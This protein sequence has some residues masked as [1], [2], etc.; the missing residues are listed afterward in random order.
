MNGH[1]LVILQVLK[2]W[3]MEG[4]NCIQ[5]LHLHFPNDR[6]KTEQQRYLYPGIK[7]VASTDEIGI[8]EAQSNWEKS[9]EAEDVSS[10]MMRQV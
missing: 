10:N 5:T 9:L 4:H 3:D 6:G 8:R 7:H 1:V 2:V